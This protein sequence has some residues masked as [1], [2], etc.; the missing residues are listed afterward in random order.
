[1]YTV[2]PGGCTHEGTHWVDVCPG[3]QLAGAR[4]EYRQCPRGGVLEEN[5]IRYDRTPERDSTPTLYSS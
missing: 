3:L 1:M 4:R 5:C 2:K